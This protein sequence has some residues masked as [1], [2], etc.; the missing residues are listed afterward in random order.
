M[1]PDSAF[2]R[3][4]NLRAIG[5]LNEAVDVYRQFL[6]RFPSNVDARRALAGVLAELGKIDGAISN[7]VK[8][9][10]RLAESGDILGAIA[11]GLKVMEIDPRLENPLSH[12]AKTQT[13]RLQ[14]QREQW[15]DTRPFT[16]REP[17]L[18]IPLLYDL[19]PAELKAVAGKMRAHE[20]KPGEVIF[21]EGDE[22]DSVFFVHHGLVEVSSG[23]HQLG[24]LGPGECLGEFSF[25]TR[26]PRTATVRALES[27]ELLELSAIDMDSVVRAHPRLRELLYQMYRERALS[28]VLARS[29]LFEMLSAADRE[30]VVAHVERIT[31]KQG[32][33]VV[34]R[35]EGGG[36]LYLVKSGKLEV[37]A[38]AL[39]DEEIKLATLKPHQFFGEVSFLTGV[40]RTATVIA[41]EES[42]LLK[43][44]EGE[45]RGLVEDYPALTRILKRYHL[46]RVMATAETLKSFLK[47][48]RV[49]GVV[50]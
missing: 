30:R 4:E 49:E 5:R 28:N 9:Q 31:V 15:A 36:A 42:E 13:E 48:G 11:A 14:A 43:I 16:P 2:E 25:L 22:G 39:N 27:T 12:L 45:L 34:R 17:F 50:R 33:A 37:R 6:D 38:E 44:D 19:N 10:E 46:D 7:Y 47:K 20:K 35:G 40:P 21:A 29:P 3:A 1:N 18:E 23:S 8:V 26:K 41:L 24:Q 32:E